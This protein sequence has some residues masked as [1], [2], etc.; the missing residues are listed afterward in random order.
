MTSADDIA[1]GVVA[2]LNAL[3]TDIKFTAVNPP[4][5][6]EVDR[7]VD[8]ATVHVTPYEESEE[9]QTSTDDMMKIV[10]TVNVLL[11]CPLTD[12]T[13]AQCLAWLNQIK[14]GFRG[15]RIGRFIWDKND[16]QALLV[17]VALKEKLQFIAQFRATFYDYA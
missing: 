11:Q 7:S 8:D 13:R 4:I 10:R 15:A 3:T 12:Y 1:D 17:S 6:P 14:E 16:E 2:I 5:V 9:S